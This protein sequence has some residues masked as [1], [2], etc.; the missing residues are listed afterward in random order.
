M[1]F[2]IPKPQQV[3]ELLGIELNGW[4]KIKTNRGF[5]FSGMKIHYFYK[6]KNS[7]CGEVTDQ[8]NTLVKCENVNYKKC[9]KCLLTLKTY[10]DLENIPK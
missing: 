6:S 1:S 3:K 2:D 8:A 10:S 5:G 7:I 4:Y 9:R